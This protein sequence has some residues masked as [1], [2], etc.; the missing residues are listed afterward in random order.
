MYTFTI[1]YKYFS[2]IFIIYYCLY[3]VSIIGQ[4]PKKRN[5]V[6]IIKNYLSIYKKINLYILM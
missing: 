6:I 2:A 5:D 4:Y 3:N 1:Y